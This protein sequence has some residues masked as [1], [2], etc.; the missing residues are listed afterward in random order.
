MNTSTSEIETLLREATRAGEPLF[1]DGPVRE[2]A[3]LSYTFSNQ[4]WFG[5]RLCGYTIQ[6]FLAERADDIFEVAVDARAELEIAHGRCEP[7]ITKGIVVYSM[8][9]VL[10][11]YHAD[12]Q[13]RGHAFKATRDLTRLVREVKDEIRLRNPLRCKH[14]QIMGD[15][16]DTFRAVIKPTPETTFESLIVDRRMVEDI[17]DNT[18]FQLKHTRFSNGVIFYGEP[19]T[20]K[21]LMCQAIIH[22]AVREGFSSCYLVGEVNFSELTT[23]ITDYLAPCVVILEDIDSFAGERLDGEGLRLADFLQFLSG[24]TERPEQLIVVATTNHLHLLDKAVNNRPV[25][26][27]RKY[28]F[29]RPSDEEVDR[30][31]DLYFEASQLTPDLRRLCHGRAFTGAHVSEIRRTALT[32]AKK[33]SV[34]VKEVFAEAVE[35]VSLHFS[36][37]L[38]SLGFSS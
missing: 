29:T 13:T 10:L 1:S 18:L 9:G 15:D 16:E 22:E 3:L 24:L 30:L 7:V 34:P 26:F 23:F 12:P 8:G 27:N 25:R 21:S 5:Y 11:A 17:Y 38:K 28:H 32:L 37:T 36:T 33:R 20:G 14:L 6:R 19:G 35:M 2:D 4:T 31:L